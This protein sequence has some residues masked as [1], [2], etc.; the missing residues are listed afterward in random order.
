MCVK[1][2]SRFV[3]GAAALLSASMA[4]AQEPD[5]QIPGRPPVSFPETIYES[6]P[7]AATAAQEFSPVP[8][9]WR[10]FYAGKWYDPYNQN[11]LKGDIPVFGSAAHPWFTE[12]SVISDT[13]VE[14][15]NLPV[16]V[17]AATTSSPG[18]N[19]TFGSFG[20][21]VAAQNI[22]TSFALI[23]GNTSF[24][25][26]EFELRIA[27]VFGLNYG[28]IAETG[29][30]RIDPAEGPT[31]TDSFAGLLELFA[32][33]HLADLS[34]RYDFLSS[35]IGV[36][37]FNADF[38]GF[39]FNAEEPGVRLFGNLEN[40]IWQFNLAYF[41][42]IDKDTNSGLNSWFQDRFEDVVVANLYRQ[43]ALMLG[44]TMLFS[45]VHREDN[46]GEHPF[47]YDNN[48]FLVRPVSLGDQRPKNLQTTYI[49]IG[50]DGHFGRINSVAQ[51]YYAFGSE[52][53]NQ[54]ARQPIDVSAA[55][56]A[57]ELSYDRDWIRYRASLFWA[58]G[59]SDARDDKGT[60][61]D[62]I[63]DN[64]NFAGGALS[65]WQRNGIPFIGGGGT[66]LV[67]RFS[68]L[69]SLRPG[70]EEGQANFVNPGVRLLNVGV[71]FELTPKLKLINN[72]SYL[73]FDQADVIANLRQDGSF[74]REIGFDISTG[75]FYRPFL[76]NNI[77]IRAGAGALVPGA[78]IKNLYG[79]ELLYNIFTTLTLLY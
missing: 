40:N 46:A 74:S 1:G 4:L 78:A 10:Q 18:S 17:G 79:D 64:P 35:R 42:R 63:L 2:C 22:V 39:L 8:D 26:P 43:D 31:R 70:Y 36:Q 29:I 58:S 14:C 53:H 15:R 52:S 20:Q 56:A 62:S 30:L 37:R 23:N 48:G 27:P 54:I 66:N 28:D 32:D 6:I 9:R 69:P 72:V 34:D 60:G 49:G 38:R 16:P 59:D 45:V 12:I 68:L 77:Q 3:L 25:P 57:W 61:F 47:D 7:D 55:M 13:V 5:R 71:D 73:Q 24:K 44:H 67:N 19:D 76:S 51:F 50:G 11:V 75:I 33:V 41:R 65:F 21:L